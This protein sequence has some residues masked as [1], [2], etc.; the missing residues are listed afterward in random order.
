MYE[1][2]VCARENYA[3]NTQQKKKR[4]MKYS[5]HSAMISLRETVSLL[6]LIGWF[7]RI[8]AIFFYFIEP[9]L[10]VVGGRESS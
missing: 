4:V 7:E 3:I 2:V 10:E 5:A 6:Q 9:S 1:F 8:I